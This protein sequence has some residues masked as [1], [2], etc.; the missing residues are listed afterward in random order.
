MTLDILI[1]TLDEGIERVAA[2][3]L[4]QRDG[5][6]YLISW[7]H[8]SDKETELPD[9]LKRDDVK[10]LHLAGRGLSRNRNNCIEH[11]TADVCLIADDDCLYTHEQLQKVIDTFDSNTDVDIVTFRYSGDNKFYPSQTTDLTTFPKGYYVSSIEIAFKRESVQGKVWFN[12]NFGLGT[13][14]FYCGEEN[15]FIQDAL[16]L[17]LTCRFFPI[18]IVHDQQPMDF[19]SR[20]M[21][22][23]T[24]MA[25]GA[26]L[27]IFHRGTKYLRA[28]L[29]A[30]RM[31]HNEKVPFFHGLHHICKGICYM[32]HHPE[33]LKNK[34]NMPQ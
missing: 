23:G 16:S 21:D 32:K 28:M 1:C 5:I 30:W 29:K 3:L 25:H 7:Q 4:P 20:S 26:D 18:T 10:V 19:L 22:K 14:P 13:E 12:E 33:I 6:S 17:G 2:M 9:E 11:S 31:K 8:S 24:L 34:R 15:L 27:Q